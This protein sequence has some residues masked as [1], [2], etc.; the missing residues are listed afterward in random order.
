MS[1]SCR[2]VDERFSSF[3][4]LILQSPN[5][6]KTLWSTHLENIPT[7]AG[8]L[9]IAAISVAQTSTKCYSLSTCF[10]A[11]FY[12]HTHSPCRPGNGQCVLVSPRLSSPRVPRLEVE[13]TPCHPIGDFT[14]PCLSG[15]VWPGCDPHTT[16]CWPSSPPLSAKRARTSE[17]YWRPSKNGMRCCKSLSVGSFI[18]PCIGIALSMRLS[19]S[20][21]QPCRLLGPLPP[22]KGP[23]GAGRGPDY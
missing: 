21:C 23:G 20:C 16:M 6:H 15:P 2:C 5:L 13:M 14:T 3:Y 1:A 11:Q 8:D 10:F 12:T 19:V 17:T 18:Q 9:W 4:T 22:L 7:G